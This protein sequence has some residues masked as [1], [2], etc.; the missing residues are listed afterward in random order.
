[1]IDQELGI[2]SR[3][4][5]PEFGTGVVINVKP[6]TYIVVFTEK[7]RLEIS[8]AYHAME[9]VEALEPDTDNVSFAEVE[10]IFTGIIRRF[11]D[12]QETVPM[13]NKWLG[14]K[15][16][17]EP[18]TAG[19]SKKEVPIEVFFNKIIMLRDRLR[20]MEQRINAH[21]KLSEEEKINLQQYLTRIYGSL[22]TFNILFKEEKDHFV[23]ERGSKSSE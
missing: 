9:L 10:R 19:L 1:M 22:T 17:L 5:H 20:V 6:K 8:K 2:G 7:G 12:V 4:R 23:G 11:S 3:I 16:V 18:G 13:G 21:D 15:M 14:G